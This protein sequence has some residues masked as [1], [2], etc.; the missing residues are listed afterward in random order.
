MRKRSRY[1]ADEDE[2]EEIYEV[3]RIVA[4]RMN[5]GRKEYLL[6]WKGYSE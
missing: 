4:H 6:K 2:D 5:R 3:E 1:H